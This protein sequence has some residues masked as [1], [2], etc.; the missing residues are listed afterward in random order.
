MRWLWCDAVP[1]R[2]RLAGCFWLFA[3]ESGEEAG[4]YPRCYLPLFSSL[5]LLSSPLPVWLYSTRLASTTAVR[6]GR[7]GGEGK[8][9]IRLWC[10]QFRIGP[11]HRSPPRARR[12]W[13]AGW[14]RAR[15]QRPEAPLEKGGRDRCDEWRREE[16]HGNC[17]SAVVYSIS[18][19]GL[20]YLHIFLSHFLFQTSLV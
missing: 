8:R 13:S 2:R 18:T 12:R 16:K 9:F 1:A 17:L 11:P 15:S 5:S 20:Y 6:H 4:I 19:C 7:S 14:G 3:G 10:S